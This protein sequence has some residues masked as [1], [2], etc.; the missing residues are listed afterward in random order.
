MKNSVLTKQTM[1]VKKK[2]LL[3]IAAVAASVVLPWLLHAAGH[4]LHIGTSV[5]EIFLPMHIF[6][7]IAGF[8]LGPVYGAVAGIAS[9]TLSFMITGMPTSLML[10]FMIV[11]LCAYGF[12]AGAVR[13]M[14][15]NSVLKV[16][17][18]QLLGRLVKAVA[19]LTAIGLFNSPLQAKIIYTSIIMGL[20]GIA[21]Q[22]IIIPFIV[23]KINE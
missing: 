22:L 23:K 4:V 19:I 7:M 5:G 2:T 9:P 18:V 17:A 10:P 13:N 21:L 8:V 16:G 3:M 6:V 1:N 14:R 11:E 15:L 12:F 20:P